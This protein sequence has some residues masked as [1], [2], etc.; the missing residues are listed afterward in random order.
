MNDP[1][2]DQAFEKWYDSR[3]SSGY[4]DTAL[5]GWQAC[6]RIARENRWVAFSEHE[7]VRLQPVS[8]DMLNRDLFERNRSRAKA[9]EIPRKGVKMGFRFRIFPLA[10]TFFIRTE[11]PDGGQL[12]CRQTNLS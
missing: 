3:H 4:F 9:E 12:S 6:A 2:S 1:L 10:R 7:L 8:S 5:S 11:R